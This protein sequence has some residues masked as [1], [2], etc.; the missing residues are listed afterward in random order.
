MLATLATGCGGSANTTPI[1]QTTVPAP[2]ASGT[3]S[4]NTSARFTITVP[5]ATALSSARKPAYISAST[6]SVV[7][8][9]VSVNGTAYTGTTA[10]IASNLTPSNPA[11]SGTPLTCSVSAPAV[12][13]TDMYTVATYD[14]AQ[15]ATSP[16]SALG[17]LLSKA[18]VSVSVPAGQATT[19][20]LTLNGVVDHLDLALGSAST[21]AGTPSNIAIAVN[22]RDK[23]DNII[24][25]SGNFIDASGNPLTIHLTDSDSSGETSIAPSTITAP[26]A[27]VQLIY[28]GTA[29]PPPTLGLTIGATISGG[30]IANGTVTAQAFTV[31][32]PPTLTTLNSAAG[33]T[34]TT[35]TKTLSGTNFITGAT[36]VA[37]DGTGVSAA[38]VNVTSA[39]SLT[40]DFTVTGAAA[41]GP[42]NVT[43][44]TAGG[45]SASQIMTIATGHIV[46]VLTDTNA[47]GA[48][49]QGAGVSGDLRFAM[50]NA[51]AGDAIGFN[52]ASPCTITLNG[53]LPVI[54]HD[55]TIFG[56]AFGDVIIDGNSAYRAFFVDSGT[57][58]LANL[59]IQN[60]LAQ[61]GAGGVGF[62]QAGGG[63][64]G[65]GAG[66]LVNQAS[67]NVSVENVSFVGAR[68]IGGAGGT[69]LA[70]PALGGGGGGGGGMRF[71]GGSGASEVSAVTG[72]GGGGGG[73]LGAGGATLT[74]AGG[75]AG[76]GG[77]GAGGAVSSPTGGTAGVFGGGGG[78]GGD[79]S[80]G[81]PGG[82][83][84]GGGGNGS[85]ALPGHPGGPGGGGGVGTPAGPGGALG[86]ASR[87]GNSGV[88][89]SSTQPGGGG[90]GAAAGPAIFVNVGTLTAVQSG[91][92]GAT[93]IPGAGGAAAGGVPGSPGTADATAVFSF[94]GKINGAITTGPVSGA[95]SAS[96]PTGSA[97]TLGLRHTRL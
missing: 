19:V 2:A 55:L 39:T 95:L 45:S 77:G 73:L 12:V 3:I 86:G 14:A 62:G 29:P 10:T 47:G 11:C 60:V 49:G 81:S 82:F 88:E 33:W 56:D 93:A 72:G 23:D 57:V 27:S 78:G 75:A 85:L 32:V 61:G 63:G 87:G 37:V 22:A 90:G 84:G 74:S 91:S 70:E 13:G 64:L 9:L 89:T 68:A 24:I 66:L 51:G 65:T 8:T 44:S 50:N 21:T 94:H 26:S 7:V 38:N 17:N 40:A 79:L 58:T 30:T 35:I 5:V 18:N 42:R 31:L 96:A 20:T 54:S 83:G 36:T 43:V 16:D 59:Q 97:T 46:T 28:T 6:Q 48:A 67:A 4:P 34:N 41:L 76:A 69:G 1:A 15:I 52:C 53:P 80:L 25:G 92:T 71:A